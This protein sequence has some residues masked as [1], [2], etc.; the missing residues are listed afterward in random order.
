MKKTN[1]LM[2]IVLTCVMAFSVLFSAQNVSAAE[3]SGTKAEVEALLKECYDNNPA[4]EKFVYGEDLEWEILN[5]ARS[6]AVT[7]AQKKSYCDS[8]VKALQAE[9]RDSFAYASENAKVVL[10]LNAMK[11]DPTNV[12]GYNLVAPLK[13]EASATA[14]MYGLMYTMTALYSTDANASFPAY[15]DKLITFQKKSGGFDGNDGDAYGE[16][17]DS[18]AMA[19]QALAP[20][21]NKDARVKTVVD[22]GLTYLVTCMDATTGAITNWGTP[23]SNSTAQVIL[24]LTSLGINPTEDS[25]FCQNGKNLITALQS[26][27]M[28]NGKYGYKS[29]ADTDAY[30][31][32]YASK[33]SIQA[34]IAYNRLL[35]GQTSFYDYSDLR[36]PAVYKYPIL[37]GAAQTVDTTKDGTLSIRIDCPI[38]KFVGVE[39]DG[40]IVDPKY[41]TV[42]SGSTIVTFTSEYVKTLKAGGH[43]VTVNFTDGSATVNVE[44]K[45]VASDTA[46]VV[47]SP[48]T[49]ESFPVAVCVMM[50]LAAGAVVYARKC[51]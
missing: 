38:E 34:M 24:A 50:V 27:Y 15:V 42:T 49:G 21:Y 35:N 40:V 5:Y 16:D 17:P 30:S 22:A 4:K 1:K 28:G 45:D 37:E 44:V 32:G 51:A 12:G 3:F 46:E 26:F 2:A 39:M 41:Y 31:I 18:T 29:T 36:Q 10:V 6:G 23:N 48:K 11:C 25:R 20:Y 8:V 7:E 43:A 19:I 47:K 9:G 13:D 33:Q 14:D